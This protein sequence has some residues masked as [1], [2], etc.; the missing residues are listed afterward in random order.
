MKKLSILFLATFFASCTTDFGN[1]EILS[2]LPNDLDEISGIEITPKSPLLWMID[3]HGNKPNLYGYNVSDKKVEKEIPVRGLKKID[4]EDL[5]SDEEGNL[6]I[7]DFGNNKSK[8][9]DLA[10]YKLLNWQD[11]LKVYR[12]IF[13][14]EDQTEYPPKDNSQSFDVEAFIATKNSF[15]IFTRNRT[16]GFDGT[17]SV[18]R[19][20]N[21]P[22]QND[23]VFLGKL[24]TCD[25][26]SN[27]QI[28]S[29]AIDHATGKIALLSHDKVWI[30]SD[31]PEGNLLEGAVKKIQLEHSSQK[32]SIAFGDSKTLYIVD[33]RN[34][35]EGGNL[36][37]L[38]ID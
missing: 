33:E 11:T 21:G 29:A 15:Y 32:E 22:G 9:K 25:D 14:F 23:A 18:Y 12:S 35:T 8:R 20:I 24:K 30:I 28:T 26:K 34:G 16:D 10:I 7:G 31:Y 17:T 27:C 19:I 3:D 6:Y 1:I 13:K 38:T 5:A 2:S 36:Y 37:K 4:W